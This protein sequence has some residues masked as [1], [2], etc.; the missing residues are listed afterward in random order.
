MRAVAVA[1]LVF[2]ATSVLAQESRI[3]GAETRKVRDREAA[4][5]LHRIHEEIQLAK[6]WLKFPSDNH[7]SLKRDI[8]TFRASFPEY[9]PLLDLYLSVQLPG[10][11]LWPP[12]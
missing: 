12:R 8:E 10:A 7:Y 1:L 2:L 3:P 6:R 11:Q 4:T 5:A 9:A